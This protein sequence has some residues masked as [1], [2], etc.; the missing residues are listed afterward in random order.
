MTRARHANVQSSSLGSAPGEP[1]GRRR[2]ER[3]AD[4]LG[5]DRP[6]LT[7]RTGSGPTTLRPG[8]NTLVKPADSSTRSG[9]TDPSRGTRGVLAGGI[10]GGTGSAPTS[11]V[12]LG[13]ASP[14]VLTM[15][16]ARS[17][18]GRAGVVAALRMGPDPAGS[19]SW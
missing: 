6:G 15:R 12:G 10:A 7:G 16:N 18:Y 17:P 9:Q 19:A 1:S 2:A 13:F 11:L 3:P 5:P 14:R 8:L 4:L